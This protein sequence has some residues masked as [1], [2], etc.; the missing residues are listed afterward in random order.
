MENDSHD[1]TNTTATKLKKV[2]ATNAQKKLERR[3]QYFLSRA[4][5]LIGGLRPWDVK[6]HEPDLYR[7][8]LTQGSLG[9]GEAYMDGW[10]DV[11]RLDEFLF[12]VLRSHLYREVRHVWAAKAL[13][14]LGTLTNRQSIRRSRI[15]GE[16]HYDIG[17]DLY[18]IMLDRRMVY[19]C[20]YWKNA[21]DLDEAQEHK[22]KLICDKLGL[23]KGQRILDIGCGWGSLAKYAAE[24]YGAEVVGITISK[25]QAKLATQRCQGLPIEIRVQDYRTM[26][27]KK[28]GMFD[29]I[30][31]VG[32]FEHVG[33][34]NYRKYFK[35]AQ[36]LLKDD[37]L[38]LLH[39]IGSTRTSTADPWTDRYIFHGGILPTIAQVAHGAHDLF[40]LEDLHNF[41]VDYDKTLMAWHHNFINAWPKLKEKYDERFYRMWTYYLLCCA[42]SFRARHIQLWQFV[43]SK[44][45]VAGGYQSTR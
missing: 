4:D 1:Q 20:G 42:G 37:G 15:V 33:P 9:L 14:L 6:V 18:E 16:K 40:V 8:V 10:F 22:L 2:A 19:S 35:T 43:F 7:R 45:G 3:M 44:D 24:N 23:K 30:V 39:T 13:K 12:R 21:K 5:I 11:E 36:S 27:P 31:S 28:D 38:F 25:E 32:M 29:H 26:T 17:N 41:G 34:K